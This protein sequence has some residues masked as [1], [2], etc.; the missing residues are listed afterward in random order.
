MKLFSKK[1]VYGLR[2]VLYIASLENQQQY[3]S[4]LQLSNDLKISFHFLTKILQSLSQNNIVSSHRGRNG[5]VSLTKQAKK[6]TLIEIISI[7]EGP[8]FFNGCILC[9]PDCDNEMPCPLH[10]YWAE[11][12]DD[13]KSIFENT[14]IEEL[15]EKIRNDGLRLMP[16]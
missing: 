11:I 7:L 3:V 2:A 5:G 6:I 12:R 15:G 10:N 9:L 16:V 14:N 4:T 8:E 1:S 13:L